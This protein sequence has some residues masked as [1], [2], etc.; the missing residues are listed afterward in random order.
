MLGT[1]A[2]QADLK[3]LAAEHRDLEDRYNQV[4]AEI[5]SR[6]PRYAEVARPQPL[7]LKDVQ[8]QVLDRDTVLLE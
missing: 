5:R 2:S 6:S 7:S 8:K 3:T 4:Q 1:P